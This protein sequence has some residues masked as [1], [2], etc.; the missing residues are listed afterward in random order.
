MC[1]LISEQ[2]ELELLYLA[3]FV[4]P[5][6]LLLEELSSWS[7]LAPP[8]SPTTSSTSNDYLYLGKRIL[9]LG[10]P[11]NKIHSGG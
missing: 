8:P 11:E 6:A 10:N 7:C 2:D 9:L 5:S 4:S 1:T 3:A